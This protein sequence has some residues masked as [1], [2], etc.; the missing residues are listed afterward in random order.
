MGKESEEVRD[1]ARAV[2]P[3]TIIVTTMIMMIISYMRCVTS[4]EARKKTMN[5]VLDEIWKK[6]ILVH[7]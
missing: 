7:F 2:G 5:T 6:R 1:P 3:I 4:N